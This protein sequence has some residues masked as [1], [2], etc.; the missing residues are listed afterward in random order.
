MIWLWFL[1]GWFAV[2]VIVVASYAFG[3]RVGYRSAQDK[4]KEF[5]REREL[6]RNP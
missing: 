3:A 6:P 1:L 5:A 4:F 2:S